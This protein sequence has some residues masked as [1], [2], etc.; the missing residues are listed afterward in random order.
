MT[1]LLVALLAFAMGFAP[2]AW[3]RAYRPPRTADG[4]PDLQ[5]VWTNAWLTTLERPAQFETLEIPEA[6]AAAFEAGHD[7]VPEPAKGG[8]V[9]QEDSEWWEIGR[10]LGR[11]DGRARSS[12]IIAPA[13]GRLPYTPAGSAKLRARQQEAAGKFD[14]PEV[15]PAAERCLLSL[16]GTSLPPMLNAGYNNLLRI[17]QTADNVIV[18]E[19]HTGPRIVPLNP[20]A[21]QPGLAWSGHSVGRWDGDTLVVETTGFHGQAQFRAPSR[22]YIS[23]AG[24]VTERF[25]RT[26]PDEIHYAFT[27]DDPATYSQP[28]RGEMPLQRSAEAMFE[29][30]CH[31]GNYSLPGILAGAR[32]QER[33]SRSGR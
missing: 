7:G 5:G 28:W 19:M 15:R 30:A 31:E 23:S 29:F 14:G 25:T 12:W 4:H 11:L 9:G 18:P 1:V 27:V 13:D 2:G 21:A 26:S 22:L 24:K 10:A 20:V 17:V 16:G 8:P 32:E 3:G 6:Q 33:A